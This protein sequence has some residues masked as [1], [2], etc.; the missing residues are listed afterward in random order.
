[1]FNRFLLGQLTFDSAVRKLLQR[2]PLDLVARHAI[3]D[4]GMVSPEQRKH[5]LRAMETGEEILSE[6][7]ANPHEPDGPRIRIVTCEGWKNTHL[8]LVKRPK[9][10]ITHDTSF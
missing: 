1:M 8:S 2:V 7:L 9:K 4:F 10:R 3:G 6:Y 5:N